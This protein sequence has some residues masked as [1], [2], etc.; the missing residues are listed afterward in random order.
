MPKIILTK[1]YSTEVDKLDYEL[2]GS[3]NWHYS[4][5]YAVQ[6]TRS[7]TVYLHK[8]V[9]GDGSD[10]VDHINGDKLDN[11]KINLRF[12]TH[13][14]NNMNKPIQSNNTTGAKGVH[15]LK[16]TGM[17]QSYI[18]LNGKRIHIGTYVTRRMA[19]NAYNKK[20]RELFGAFA[21]LNKE[22]I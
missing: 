9:I 20:A 18:K 5:G 12:A 14:Q 2:Y 10:E 7:G 15:R 3:Q 21:V 6:R 19:A 22:E 1:G 16:S 4:H 17:Y 13:S 11:R 8:L